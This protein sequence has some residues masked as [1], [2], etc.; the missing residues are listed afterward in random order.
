MSKRAMNPYSGSGQLGEGT[1]VG[2]SWD[3]EGNAS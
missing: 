2:E 1:V 3:S